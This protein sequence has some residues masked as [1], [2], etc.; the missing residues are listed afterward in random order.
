MSFHGLPARSTRFRLKEEAYALGLVAPVL[1]L[2][3][4]RPGPLVIALLGRW[5]CADR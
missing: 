3:L 2:T 1:T 5:R 4:A